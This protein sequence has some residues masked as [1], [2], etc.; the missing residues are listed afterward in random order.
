MHS[1]HKRSF[2]GVNKDA[3]AAAAQRNNEVS[4]EVPY[5]S[6]AR[7]A[8]PHCNRALTGNAMNL[9]CIKPATHRQDWTCN[10]G[11]RVCGGTLHPQI[12]SRL[13]G[14]L[15]VKRSNP[16][17][18]SMQGVMLGPRLDLHGTPSP[19]APP[20]CGSC[21]C[22][23]PRRRLQRHIRVCSLHNHR[24]VQEQHYVS[25]VALS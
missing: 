5:S 12:L 15:K 9:I 11:V 6:A 2:S 16:S 24:R 10:E 25:Q 4:P 7:S 23:A 17:S 13:R 3:K 1:H 18:D 22:A 21:P 8:A 14:E 19:T 20:Q